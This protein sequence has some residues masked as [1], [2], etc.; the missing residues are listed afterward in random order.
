MTCYES[1]RESC[2]NQAL[3]LGPVIWRILS[4]R[5]YG[6]RRCHVFHITGARLRPREAPVILFEHCRSVI[7]AIGAMTGGNRRYQAVALRCRYVVC[8]TYWVPC[9]RHLP[10]CQ[11]PW[12]S[13]CLSSRR[14]ADPPIERREELTQRTR[15]TQRSTWTHMA[16]EAFRVQISWRE[17]PDKVE[18][19]MSSV[20]SSKVVTVSSLMLCKDE[21]L[22]NT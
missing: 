9:R 11:G 13:T 4:L 5:Q 8:S 2:A 1:S 10:R 19:R 21:T 18:F 17:G 15:C 3:F 16:I 12:Q 14:R 6:A 7:H 22:D 20:A